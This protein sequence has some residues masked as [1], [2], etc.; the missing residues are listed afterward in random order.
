MYAILAYPIG[1]FADKIGMKKILLFGLLIF[2]IVYFGFAL[3]NNLIIFISLFA[4]YGLYAAAT[5]GISKAWISNMVAKTETATAIGTYSGLQ[6]IASLMASSL[7]GLLWY[8]YGATPTF[9][10]TAFVTI[11]V[12]IYL[13][14]NK[15]NVNGNTLIN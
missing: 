3:T 15:E 7:C 11:I 8:N 14:L 9:L 6:S 4:L 5:E 10:I 1:L 13:T 12:V 2:A